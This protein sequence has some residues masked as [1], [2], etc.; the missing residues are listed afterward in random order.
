MQTNYQQ[1]RG[2]SSYI[3]G[4]ESWLKVSKYYNNLKKNNY[5]EHLSLTTNDNDHGGDNEASNRSFIYNALQSNGRLYDR[6][7]TGWSYN[8]DGTVQSV[9]V[10]HNNMVRINQWYNSRKE[11]L[12]YPKNTYRSDYNHL[13]HVHFSWY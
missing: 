7:V 3:P 12:G 2:G 10:R 5:T 6:Y 13:N 11:K 9:K 1:I 4:S 8:D